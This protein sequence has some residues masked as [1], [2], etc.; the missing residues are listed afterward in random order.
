MELPES[1][2]PT[3][4]RG[5]LEL[6]AVAVLLFAL[7]RSS[8]RF[9]TAERVAQTFRYTLLAAVYVF[10]SA[11]VLDAFMTQWGFRGDR[12]PF[13]FERM[14]DH[15]AERPYVYRV[16]SPEII[17]LGA[18]M[19]P[20]GFV[21]SRREWLLEETP[22]LAYRQRGEGWGVDK[23]LKWH[24]AYFYLFACLVAALFAA[25]RLTTVTLD[26]G[27]LF[28]DYAPA[29][30]LLCLPASFHWGGYLYDFPELLLLLLCSLALARERLAWFYP[31][32]VLAILNKESNV[33]VFVFFLAFLWDRL[34]RRQL[35][36]HLL[37]QLVLGWSLVLVL[38][39]AFLDNEGSQALF[40]FPLNALFW[41]SPASYWKFIEPY[42]P[43]I[44]IPRPANALTLFLVGFAVAWGW[45]RKPVALRRLL[46]GSAAVTLPLFLLFSFADEARALAL[47]FPALYLLACDT[48]R[49]V[50]RG[51]AQGA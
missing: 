7:H 14:L 23:S 1:Y 45:S 34:P 10:V 44:P 46:L 18:G 28:S 16:L 9:V 6:A 19:V 32:Y 39:L 40:F 20:D 38:R 8:R 13:A 50:Y 4:L 3:L 47:L 22:L 12:S 41:L 11:L 27:P 36:L 30:A 25:R 17:A 37:A 24:V 48:V 26:V 29:V 43:L 31:L 5:V 2:F 35:W 15:T 42:A 33:L 21:E 49:D 51:R